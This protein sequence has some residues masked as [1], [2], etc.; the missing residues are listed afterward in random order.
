MAYLEGEGWEFTISE[1]WDLDGNHHDG[2]PS[3]EDMLDAGQMTGHYHDSDTGDDRY[4]T[5]I[6]EDGWT[7]EELYGEFQ[8]WYQEGTE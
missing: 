3:A 5:F 8:D 2:M 7:D 4:M 1:W 6:S